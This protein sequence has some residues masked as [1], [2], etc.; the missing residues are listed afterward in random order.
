MDY[1]ELIR[2]LE[3]DLLDEY[4]RGPWSADDWDHGYNAGIRR[5]IELIKG[6]DASNDSQR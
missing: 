3:S 2:I 4:G 6:K 5:A 1:E